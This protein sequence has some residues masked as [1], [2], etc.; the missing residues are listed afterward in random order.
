MRVNVPSR[1]VLRLSCVLYIKNMRREKGE[2]EARKE[3]GRKEG[4]GGRRKGMVNF[5]Q[6]SLI[7]G[8]ANIFDIAT[9]KVIF[10]E[11]TNMSSGSAV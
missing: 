8:H 2:E 11:A 3:G 4:E 7:K 1:V 9:G 10:F 5:L 6:I